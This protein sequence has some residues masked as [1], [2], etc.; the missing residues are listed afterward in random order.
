MAIWVTWLQDA[1]YTA[2]QDRTEQTAMLTK[3]AV[4]SVRGGLVPSD[5]TD[6]TVT[7]QGTPNMT[8]NV[9]PFQA[10][11]PDANGR[12]Y[13]YTSDS[14]VV[15]P[16]FATASGSHPRIDLL[17]ARVYDNAAGDSAA[18]TSLTLPGSAG[19]ITVQSVTG[20]VEIVTGTPAA[21]PTAPALPNTR[22][23]ILS[24][25]TVPTSAT[26]IVTGDIASS[27]G[28]A[29]RAPFTVAAGGMLPVTTFS[30]L[31][32]AAYEGMPG[33][34][35]DVNQPYV[36]DGAV[37]R[38]G[39]QG[40]LVWHHIGDLSSAFGANCTDNDPTETNQ[41]RVGFAKDNLGFVHMRGVLVC[42]TSKA[43]AFAVINLPSGWHALKQH[44]YR[45]S[46]LNNTA[47]PVSVEIAQ[48]PN[49]DFVILEAIGTAGFFIFFDNIIFEADGS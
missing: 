15:S 16:A 12:A 4:V 1:G 3:S 41:Y 25:V 35:S 36:Y 5:G 33:W 19:S 30:A 13:V 47:A 40:P 31:P 20:T 2:A 10:V 6:A 38:P 9:S 27:G 37:W 45:V 22:C 11:I 42:S 26:S 49:G 34:A 46:V 17:I 29:T 44:T 48:N 14:S 39:G 21:S 28:G 43:A 23:I 18:T 7:A 24:V 8:V 32:A